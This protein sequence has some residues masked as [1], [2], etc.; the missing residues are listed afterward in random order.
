MENTHT[1]NE[2]R[3]RERAKEEMRQEERREDAGCLPLPHNNMKVKNEFC[4]SFALS[5]QQTYVS[6]DL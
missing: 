5:G 4:P 3:E 2:Q 6:T 1:H